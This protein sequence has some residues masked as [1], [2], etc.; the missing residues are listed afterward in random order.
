MAESLAHKFGQIVGDLLEIAIQPRLEKF[1][2]KN[3]L[4]LAKRETEKCEPAKKF[5]GRTARETNMISTLC[6]NVAGQKM[7]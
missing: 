5:R 2:K 4:F 3:K 6:L 7:K 1:A